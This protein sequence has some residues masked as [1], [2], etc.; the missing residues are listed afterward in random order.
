M[1]EQGLWLRLHLLS[2]R[3]VPLIHL[4]LDSAHAFSLFLAELLT[5][6]VPAPLVYLGLLEPCDVADI[7][8]GLLRPVRV[9]LKVIT[10]HLLLARRLALATL[11]NL[12]E[13]VLV[14]RSTLAGFYVHRAR[15]NF[16]RFA[17]AIFHFGKRNSSGSWLRS[18]LTQGLLNTF[19]GLRAL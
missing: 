4:V 12:I 10:Q 9:P 18:L 6:S 16:L 5:L 15:H 17:V 13:R 2:S 14:G 8:E 3:F 11:N 19:P 1:S 7:S